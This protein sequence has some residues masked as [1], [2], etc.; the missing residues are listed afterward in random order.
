VQQGNTQNA[1]HVVVRLNRGDVTSGGTLTS[2]TMNWTSSVTAKAIVIG[3][4]SGVSSTKVGEASDTNAS[5]TA[6]AAVLAVNPTFVWH[7]GDLLVGAVGYEGPGTDD[8]TCAEQ[9]GSTLSSVTEEGQDGTTGSTADTNITCELVWAI[10][11]ATANFSGGDD[12]ILTT[13]NTAARANAAYG[14][15]YT[16]APEATWIAKGRG[17]AI[18]A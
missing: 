12:Q 7:A 3:I 8:L 14:L 15:A 17:V 4:F 2:I 10:A 11:T 1:G 9:N 18:V 16:A 13:N 5:S 6:V